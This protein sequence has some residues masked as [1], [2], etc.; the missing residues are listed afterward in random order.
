[1][2][3]VK[4]FGYRIDGFVP[5]SDYTLVSATF[6][7]YLEN[8]EGGARTKEEES[9]TWGVGAVDEAGISAAVD[10]SARAWVTKRRS[11]RDV[12]AQKRVPDNKLGKAVLLDEA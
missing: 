5:L 8:P 3:T 6:F 7:E 11:E 1:M 2:A 9:F 10:A 4:K 12:P